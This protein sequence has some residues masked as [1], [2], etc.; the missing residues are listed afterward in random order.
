[1]L[2]AGLFGG[3]IAFYPEQPYIPGKT[4][5]AVSESVRDVV[6]ETINWRGTRVAYGDIALKALVRRA[7]SQLVFYPEPYRVADGALRD[8]LM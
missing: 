8:V 4:G 7:Y 6:P 3:K 5:R 2:T 1:V